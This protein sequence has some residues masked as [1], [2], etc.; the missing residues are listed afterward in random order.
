MLLR[1]PQPDPAELMVADFGIRG[2]D[3]AYA[4]M[5]GYEHAILVDAVV[6]SES[7]GTLYVIEP[8][9]PN[10]A[11]G[12]P[13][14]HSMDPRRVLDMVERFGGTTTKVRIVACQPERYS[15]DDG[16]GLSPA[17]ES[18]VDRAI[19][20]V[21]ELLGKLGVTVRNRGDL[22]STAHMEVRT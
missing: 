2:F 10:A 6:G 14:P 20:L 4:L 21:D 18:A 19:D 5:D 12:G 22:P 16:I 17:V 15:E 1:V 11:H 13:E 9:A 3:L 7:P 8:E